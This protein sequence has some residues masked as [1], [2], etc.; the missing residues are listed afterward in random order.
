MFYFLNVV[1]YHERSAEQN[2][3]LPFSSAVGSRQKAFLFFLCLKRC[4]AVDVSRDVGLR[5]RSYNNSL[6]LIICL[7]SALSE[8]NVGRSI[9]S[10]ASLRYVRLATNI[11][12]E[13]FL[14]AATVECP[15]IL[16]NIVYKSKWSKLNLL[17]M[18]CLRIIH[19]YYKII[20]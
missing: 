7:H 2:W 4:S 14:G 19:Y 1:M 15:N 17:I 6:C 10:F 5:K 8:K 20:I 16:T 18:L 13:N 12:A 11:L 3:S 9:I